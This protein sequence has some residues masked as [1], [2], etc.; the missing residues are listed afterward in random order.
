MNVYTVHMYIRF[1]FHSIVRMACYML[2]RGL[3]ERE[4]DID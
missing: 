4:D 2:R 3:R 1:Y